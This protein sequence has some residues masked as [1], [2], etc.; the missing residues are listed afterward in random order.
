ME[1]VLFIASFLLHSFS[2]ITPENNLSNKP[3]AVLQTDRYW[4][5]DTA[6]HKN[7]TFTATKRSFRLLLGVQLAIKSK[8]RRRFR[9]LSRFPAK[10]KKR[11]TKY[12]K[13]E[14]NPVAM[15]ASTHTSHILH[16]FFIFLHL[17]LKLHVPYA[18][19]STRVFWIN[20]DFNLSKYLGFK[21]KLIDTAF[22]R[23]QAG[24]D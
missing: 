9:P 2:A 19:P 15:H 23:S 7:A 4:Q 12:R 10:S 20:Q 18:K 22:T 24:F 1:A 17:R 3:L 5:K 16:T 21:N 14:K 8:T 13:T 11:M 6:Q